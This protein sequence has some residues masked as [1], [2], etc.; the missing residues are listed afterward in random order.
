[1]IFIIGREGVDGLFI[2]AENA[3]DGQRIES[4]PE[5]SDAAQ[6]IKKRKEK[7]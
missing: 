2:G 4:I 3:H 7:K 1:M 5:N 6:S